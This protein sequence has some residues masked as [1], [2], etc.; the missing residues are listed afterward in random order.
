MLEDVPWILRHLQ[1]INLGEY[2]E[3]EGVNQIAQALLEA[4]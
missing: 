2:P 3:E 1:M 4:A